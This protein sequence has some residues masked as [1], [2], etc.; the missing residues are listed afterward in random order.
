MHARNVF[1]KRLNLYRKGV[2]L[3]SLFFL[4]LIPLLVVNQFYGIIGN[5]YSITIFG[6]DI[7]D[8]A[9]GLQSLILG[10]EIV[11]VVVIGVIIP[12]VLALIFGKVFCSWMCPFNTISEYWQQLMRKLFP[13]RWR[14]VQREAAKENPKL[15]IYWVLL[16]V[17]FLLSLLVGFPVITFL[18]APGIISS[19]ISHLLMGM[20]LGLE[21]LVIFG[22]IIVEGFLLKRYWCKYICPVGGVLG[23]FRTPKTLRINHN[24]SNCS[25]GG[26]TEPCGTSCPLGLAP[27][28]EGLYPYCYNCGLCIK[29]CEKTGFGAL[30]YGFGKKKQ[31]KKRIK[32]YK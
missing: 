10:G 25:C 30:S 22:I 3:F 20:G 21:I 5:M 18:S 14:K 23:I 16:I 24:E 4:F 31:K 8:P 19:E 29:T 13:N 26:N 6:I 28:Y 2:Q 9:M 11:W 7:V 12:V 17:L 15:W 32:V 27:K 1:Y